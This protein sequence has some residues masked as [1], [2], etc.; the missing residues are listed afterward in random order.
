MTATTEAPAADNA[1]EPK[2][3]EV[4]AGPPA[5]LGEFEKMAW[6]RLKETI[7]AHNAEVGKLKAVAGDDSALTETLRNTPSNDPA[8]KKL[9]DQDEQAYRAWEQVRKALD[10]A[11]APQVE[12]M[13]SD[14][15]S[16]VEGITAKVDEYY[17]TIKAGQNYLKGLAQGDTDPLTGLPEIVRVKSGS[18]SSGGS[19]QRRI[20]GFDFYVNGKL[21]T[22]RNAQG[23]ESSNLAAAAK[24]VGV[25][26]EALRGAFW[27]AQETQDAEKF[28]DE[29]KFGVKHNDTV[30]EIYARKQLDEAAAEGTS[31]TPTTPAA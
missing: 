4:P 10:E 9:Q 21:A 14:V 29:V 19:G 24:A 6:G 25:E 8:I 22:S 15:A 26:T 30:F 17:K 16:Q 18:G 28:K 27:A 7:E 31:D 23:K 2:T 1:A 20:R 11:L 5:N 12:A 3:P 13:R